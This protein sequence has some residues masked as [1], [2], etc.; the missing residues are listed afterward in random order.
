MR[1]I[2]DIQTAKS[3][4]LK[5]QPAE[6]V[7]L[8]PQARQRIREVFGKD[9]APE[10]VV[11]LIISDV[12]TGGD[13]ALLKYIEK[14]EG[15]RLTRLEVPGKEITAARNNIDRELLAALQTA[16]ERIR[17]FHQKQ[18]DLLPMGRI[19][20]GEGLGQV[21]APLERVGIYAP[22]GT[23]SYPSTVLM[24]AIPARVA[25][26]NE[27]ILATPPRPDGHI[28]PLTLAAADIAGIDRVFSV[29]GAQ[30]IAALAF[31]TESIPRVD[32]I[33]G[34][35]NIFVMLAKKQVFG[36]V[37][38]DGLQGPTETIVLADDSANPA[39]C[40]ADLLAQA[41]HDELATAIM[42]TTSREL[43]R[44]VNAEVER[45]LIE[46]ERRKI[47]AVSLEQRGGI[48]IVGDMDEAIQLVNDYAPEH[49]CLLVRDAESVSA[50]IRNAGGIFIGE[51]SPE[52]IGDYVAG[53]SHVMPTGGTARFSSPLSV[54]DFLKITS[55][56][57]LDK[58]TLKKLGPQAAAIARAEGLTAHAAAIERRVD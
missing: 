33:C 9:V 57:A 41:E 50:R 46:L 8:P 37:D 23:A 21:I 14:L 4:L 6:S 1:I 44:K 10:E 43:A 15:A 24:T 11:R 7:E 25:G 3:A 30:A 13:A 48:V 49:L 34:P 40:A 55:L 54:A 38:I 2:Q 16:A 35:G 42:I 52:V 17:D 26:V 53:P 20:L 27:I 12:Q 36:A 22:G 29:G 39:S 45:Q 51:S 5:R 58:K 32:K 19:E 18:R 56:I 47:A 31:G 28:P